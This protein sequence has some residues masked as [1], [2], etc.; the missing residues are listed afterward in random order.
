MKRLLI[1]GMLTFLISC[2]ESPKTPVETS[3]IVVE[4]FYQRNNGQLEEYTT[5]GLYNSYMAVQEQMTNGKNGSSNF[6]V[7]KDTI[8]GD[9]AWVKFNSAYADRPETFKLIK[10]NGK[11]K[12]TE[13]GLRERSPF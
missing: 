2:S 8:Y 5:L 10:Q 9:T 11:W 12:V 4:S 3:Q 7:V 1:I 13:T 6:K